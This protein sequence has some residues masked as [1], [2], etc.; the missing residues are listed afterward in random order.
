MMVTPSLVG[1]SGS[2]APGVGK[3][4]APPSP[5]DHSQVM[6]D[7]SD[8]EDEPDEQD[9]ADRHDLIQYMNYL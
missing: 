7:C 4:S 8:D 5:I 6:E 2:K 3:S 1:Y 9:A